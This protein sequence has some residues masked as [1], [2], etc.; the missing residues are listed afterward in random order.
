MMK[1]ERLSEFESSVNFN[2]A[3]ME[4]AGRVYEL[5]LGMTD[6]MLKQD[7]VSMTNMKAQ[8]GDAYREAVQLM[9]SAKVLETVR[10]AWRTEMS[11]LQKMQV[12]LS[13]MSE[14]AAKAKRENRM[15]MASMGALAK[16]M[17]A[18]A[19]VHAASEGRAGIPRGP[20]GDIRAGARAGAGAM[21]AL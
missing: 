2:S 3:M 1:A 18:E 12:E 11:N 6:A 5:A 20:G 21:A 17:Q 14:E 9:G 7:P 10:E 4:S 8:Q 19:M 16:Q 13:K 15:A